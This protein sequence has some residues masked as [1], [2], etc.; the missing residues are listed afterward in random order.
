MLFKASL[1]TAVLAALAYAT[2][3]MKS[4]QACSDVTIIFARGTGETLPIG[5]VVGPL[6]E[7]AV[8]VAI[9]PRSLNFMGVN[10]AASV[11]GFLE[12][13]DPV[14]ARTMAADVTTVA[15]S[16]PN[17]QIVMSGYR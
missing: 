2:P 6:F 3:S 10:Y 12:G 16:C 5:T 11:P 9:T 13:G 14:G 4:R 7:I 1:L 17:T 15:N 8:Q